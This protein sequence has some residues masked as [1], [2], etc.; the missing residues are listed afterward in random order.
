L[1]AI[2][3]EKRPGKVRDFLEFIIESF[4]LGTAVVC[5]PF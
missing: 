1:G 2:S 5:N 3:R 4:F